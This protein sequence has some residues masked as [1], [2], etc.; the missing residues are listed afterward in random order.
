MPGAPSFGVGAD[1]NLVSVEESDLM[2]DA[3]TVTGAGQIARPAAE[4][5][6]VQPDA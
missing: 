6:G 2:G 5:G 1:L 4:G 3:E